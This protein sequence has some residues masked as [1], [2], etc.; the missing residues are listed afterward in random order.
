MVKN[1]FDKNFLTRLSNKANENYPPTPYRQ[2][3]DIRMIPKLIRERAEVFEPGAKH[4]EP[5]GT[6]SK[7][8]PTLV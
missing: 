3:N 5:I 4:S 1:S 8:R 6:A 7:Q 2:I